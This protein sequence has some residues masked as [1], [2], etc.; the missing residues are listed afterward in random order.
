MAYLQWHTTWRFPNLKSSSFLSWPGR[1]DG[2][3]CRISSPGGLLKDPP[4]EMGGGSQAC[5]WGWAKGTDILRC[6]W[7][8]G[9]KRICFLYLPWNDILSLAPK[10]TIP[11]GWWPEALRNSEF[12]HAW[13]CHHPEPQKKNAALRI[14]IQWSLCQLGH[15]AGFLGSN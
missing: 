9:D 11:F 7:F 8:P 14:Q 15:Q 4:P 2:G 10:C 12:R 13:N 5:V 1:A 6:G 3:A